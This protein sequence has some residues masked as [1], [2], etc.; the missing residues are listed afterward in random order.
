MEILTNRLKLR[1][2]CTQDLPLFAEMNGDPEVMECFPKPLTREE[3]NAFAEA[4]KKEFEERGYGLFAVEV[5]GVAPFIGFIGLHLADF[6]AS[7]TPCIEI[8]WRL[9]KA[10]WGKGYA[11]EGARAVFRLC[12]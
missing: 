7:F 11:T 12:E 6:E 2:W 9:D 10:Y 1:L 4:I 5:P 3:S 8:G